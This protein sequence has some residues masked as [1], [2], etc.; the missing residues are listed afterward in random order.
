MLKMPTYWAEFIKYA[1]WG[2]QLMNI[3]DVAI[4]ISLWKSRIS[5]V[6]TQKRVCTQ[7]PHPQ[8]NEG[9]KLNIGASAYWTLS[10]GHWKN[11]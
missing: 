6:H 11:K 9:L 3:L 4:Y 1:L 10:Y 5:I 2:V 8:I 7:A